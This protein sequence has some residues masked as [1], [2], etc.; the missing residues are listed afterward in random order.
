MFVSTWFYSLKNK[1]YRNYIIE[2]DGKGF[3]LYLPNI[4]I[5][6]NFTHQQPDSRFIIDFSGIPINKFFVGT[7]IME[8][9]FFLGACAYCFLTG[10]PIDGVSEP[11]QVSIAVAAVLYCI[12]GLFFVRKILQHFKFSESETAVTI[13]LLAFGTNLFTHFALSPSMSHV[14]SF[15]VMAAFFFLFISGRGKRDLFLV[16]ITLGLIV[17]IRPFNILCL[18]ALPFLCGS[19]SELRNRVN[20]LSGGKISAVFFPAIIFLAVIFIQPFLWYL[21]SGQF[22]IWPY[23]EA[24]F[25]PLRPKVYE[26]LFGFRSGFFIYT[27]LFLFALILFTIEMRRTIQTVLLFLLFFIPLIYILSSW[28]AWPYWDSFG[29]RPVV[30]Y[31]S[32]LAVPLAFAA[33]LGMHSKAKLFF[34]LVAGI[35]IMLNQVQNYQYKNGMIVADGMNYKKYKYSFMNFSP[36]CFGGNEDIPPYPEN[37]LEEIFVTVNDYE[38]EY[39]GWSNDTIIFDASINSKACDYTGREF[40]TSY[41]VTGSPEL[42]AYRWYF[43]EAGLEINFIHP[44]H[45]SEVKFVLEYRSTAGELKYY[46]AFRVNELP[47]VESGV[48]KRHKYTLDLPQLNSPGDVIKIYIW[49]PQKESFL[50]DNF[51]LHFSGIR[52]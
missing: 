27:P 24:G 52:K 21:Q 42:F 30:D 39:A 48:W 51:S 20:Q 28:W 10:S 35:F 26:I 37:K 17:L 14:Y 9:P 8:A 47:R 40:G 13:F 16:A 22:F 33:R 7:A 38:K 23:E 1:E 44:V 25:Y 41:Q 12:A 45:C 5:K 4:F 43:L 46:T 32:I 19:F 3:Y 29:L 11:F 49:N 6:K 15:A 2:G 36:A 18:F 31:Y 50:I 34:G